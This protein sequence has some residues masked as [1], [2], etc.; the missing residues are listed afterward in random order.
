MLSPVLAYGFEGAVACG[1]GYVF[2]G[3]KVLFD[4]PM[5]D[6][7]RDTALGLLKENGVFRTRVAKI[8]QQSGATIVTP[9]SPGGTTR[10]VLPN[11]KK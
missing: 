7:D 11:T 10:V 6:K 3:D 9:D 8:L 5:P 4:H 2:A 1:G